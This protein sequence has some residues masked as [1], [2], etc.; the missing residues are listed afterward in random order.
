[1]YTLH[2]RFCMFGTNLY[3]QSVV[4][5]KISASELSRKSIKSALL[6]GKKLAVEQSRERVKPQPRE[7]KK[8]MS[9]SLLF[10]PLCAEGRRFPARKQITHNL[11]HF[12]IVN[13]EKKKTQFLLLLSEEERRE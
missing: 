4:I 6:V 9:V 2:T 5:N 8:C 11:E 1:M 3:A 7:G 12:V 13:Q 10:L